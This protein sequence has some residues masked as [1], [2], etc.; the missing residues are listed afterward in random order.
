MKQAKLTQAEKE[1]LLRAIDES[2]MTEGQKA[3]MRLTVE[4]RGMTHAEVFE[5]VPDLTSEEREILTLTLSTRGGGKD[6]LRRSKPKV[7]KNN[8]VT[9]KAAYVWRMVGFYLGWTGQL[10]CM[11]VCAEWD[12]PLPYGPERQAMVKELDE[13]VD[14]VIERFPAQSWGGVATWAAV[15]RG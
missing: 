11:P 4:T 6:M 1:K 10:T 12:L 2:E 13:L 5:T 8:P 15:L 3:N 9:G 14:R 7:D